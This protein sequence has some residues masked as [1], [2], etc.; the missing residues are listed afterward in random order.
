MS[1]TVGTGKWAQRGIPHKGWQCVGIEDLGEPSRTCEMCE[2]MVIRYVHYME[3][4]DYP[5]A[6]GC[7]CICAGHMENDYVNAQERE[8]W[9]HNVNARRKNWLTRAWRTSRNGNDYINTDG[10]NI[11]VFQRGAGWRFRIQRDGT[12]YAVSAD[13]GF[14]AQKD[15]KLAAFDALVQTK[16]TDLTSGKTTRTS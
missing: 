3:H 2:V 4:P 5:K 8:R 14:R 7:G 15:A 6:L 11:V 10:Y 9:M 16:L 12:D 1:E 13:R